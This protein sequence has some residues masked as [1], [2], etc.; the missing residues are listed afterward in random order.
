MKYFVQ[1][2]SSGP[3]PS[4]V[5]TFIT[6]SILKLF[7]RENLLGLSIGS[8]TEERMSEFRFNTQIVYSIEK[9][10]I[11]PVLFPKFAHG[12]YEIN[13]EHV[14][15]GDSVFPS[16]VDTE[17]T[18][19]KLY[20]FMEIIKEEE[21]GFT[22]TFKITE[23]LNK[24]AEM[25][26][27]TANQISEMKAQYEATQ[28]KGLSGGFAGLTGLT[29]LAGG[30]AIDSNLEHI[31]ENEQQLLKE[32][33]ENQ[34]PILGEVGVTETQKRIVGGLTDSPAEEEPSDPS[35]EKKRVF[36]MNTPETETE[37]I[38]GGVVDKFPEGSLEFFIKAAKLYI[39]IAQINI[40]S[41]KHHLV[42]DDLIMEEN[43]LSSAIEEIG[44]KAIELLPEEVR[45]HEY[46]P[47]V[48]AIIERVIKC[49]IIL[50]Y[51]DQSLTDIFSL[52]CK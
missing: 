27:K 9:K 1:V 25:E 44:T 31:S 6:C 2:K 42:V 21:G 13:F 41:F 28:G 4:K 36:I 5:Q 48:K 26:T 46:F 23:I 14:L 3:M 20:R 16:D 47:R 8:I 24:I 19:E 11:P 52:N 35:F 22:L 37:E 38:S 32:K 40:A 7:K 30:V 29:G 33:L 50:P 43:D 10:D 39:G 18:L 45:I 49:G 17:V 51:D 34:S 15:L 12:L